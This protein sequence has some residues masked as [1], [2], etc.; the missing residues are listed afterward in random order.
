MLN[1]STN[2]LH[3]N[4]CACRESL[5]KLKGFQNKEKTLTNENWKFER[6]K[7]SITTEEEKFKHVLIL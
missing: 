7:I 5:E 6:F 2:Y 3:L 4:V 1:S